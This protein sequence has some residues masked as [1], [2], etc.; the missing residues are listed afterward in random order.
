MGGHK[1]IC[2]KLS[3]EE[4]TS[5]HRRFKLVYQEWACKVSGSAEMTELAALV[6]PSPSTADLPRCS[7]VLDVQWCPG[8]PDGKLLQLQVPEVVKEMDLETARANDNESF[9]AARK[10]IGENNSNVVGVACNLYFH[11]EGSGLP[12]EQGKGK[13][14]GLSL[15]LTVPKTA[16]TVQPTRELPPGASIPALVQRINDKYGKDLHVSH[17]G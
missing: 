1:L 4:P 13:T 12:A 2:G 17:S 7:V 14:V 3:Q 15:L 5:D 11:L 10:Q 16:W 9:L 8:A 6:L